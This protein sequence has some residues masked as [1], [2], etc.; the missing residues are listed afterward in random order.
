MEVRKELKK[1]RLKE[2]WTDGL[3][4]EVERKKKLRRMTERLKKTGD[5]VWERKGKYRD[6]GGEEQVLCVLKRMRKML[7]K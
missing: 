2:G 5:Y 1:K 6:R 4:R 3:G 7:L